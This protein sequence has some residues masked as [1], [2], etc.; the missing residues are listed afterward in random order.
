MCSSLDDKY[1][2]KSTYKTLGPRAGLLD[3]Q[4]NLMLRDNQK[5]KRS[6]RY[7]CKNCEQRIQTSV[8]SPDLSWTPQAGCGARTIC[9][10]DDT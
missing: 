2:L 6:Q 5:S 1:E 7:T 8:K 9:L 3:L 4:M 10:L